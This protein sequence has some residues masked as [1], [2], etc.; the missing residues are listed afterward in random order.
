M[1]RQTVS[2]N[3]SGRSNLR[4]CVMQESMVRQQDE[5]FGKDYGL[6]HE[7]VVTGRKVGAGR[8]FWTRL[9]HDEGLFGKVVSFVARG[10][11]EPPTSQKRAREI[12]GK[13]FFG[14]E[15]AIKHFG[16][17]P[18]RQQLAALS[19]IPFSEAVL[20]QSKDTHVLVAVFPLSIL[21]ICGKVERKLFCSHE[22]A[23]YNKQSFAKERGEVT[24][25]L[26]H[27]TS[28]NN[29][30]SKNWQ[31]QQSLIAKDDEVPSAQV[32]V[33][34]IIGHYLTTGERLFET[35]YVRTSGVDSGGFRVGVGLFGSGGL[36]VFSDWDAS[37]DGYLGVSSARKF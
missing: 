20:E 19:E 14:V 17:N 28:V 8:E 11:F 22:D 7:A 25:Q 23:W 18:P 36:G 4:R 34:T 35:V 5:D 2:P 15:E 27:K 3:D 24:W 16:V 26:V 30:T 1:E 13:N 29:S 10:G 9:A 33:Y 12:M 21:E 32:M 31:E 37:R 6:I